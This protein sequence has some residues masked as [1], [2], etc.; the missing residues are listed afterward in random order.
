[1]QQRDLKQEFEKVCD[2]LRQATSQ[3]NECKIMCILIMNIMIIFI[4]LPTSYDRKWL[5]FYT[6][7]LR[8]LAILTTC[9]CNVILGAS[10]PSS[11]L[12]SACCCYGRYIQQCHGRRIS[13][14]AFRRQLWRKWRFLLRRWI[15][16]WK[17]IV[18]L[19]SKDT[20]RKRI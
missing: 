6:L 19:A 7:I 5:G 13:R 14:Y 15:R 11:S 9:K 17:G 20:N 1:M 10:I 8:P 3:E 2:G 12:C 18:L 16:W 4:V